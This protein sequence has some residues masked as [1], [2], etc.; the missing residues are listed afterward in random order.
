MMMTIDSRP[1]HGDRKRFGRGGL[2]KRALL[3]A[4]AWSMAALSIDSACGQFILDPIPGLPGLSAGSLAWGDYDHDGRLDF[5]LT[6]SLQLSLW[7]STGLGFSDVTAAAAP[8]IPGLYDSAVAW[9]DFDN[10]GR[11][12]LLITGLTNLSGGAVS[13]LWRNTGSGFTN[14][15]I[16]GL[17]G[18]GE[19][20]VAWSD[21]DGDGRL[22]F[23]IAGTSNGVTSGAVSQLWRNTGNGFTNV[24]I[25]GLTGTYFGAVAWGDYDND[26]RPDFLITG[27]TNSATG[28]TITQLWHNTPSGFTNVP[29]PGL[30]GLY[31]S[32]IAWADYDNDGLL[33]F[34][35]EGLSGN[36]F[37]SELWRNTGSGFTNVPIPGLPGI[38]DGSLAWGDF[39]NDGRPD[40]L[41]TGLTNGTGK[42]SQ[43]WQNTGNGFSNLPIPALEGNFDNSLGCGDFDNDG[44]LDFL[45]S[46]IISGDVVAQLWQNTALSS[47][48]AP[49]APTGLSAIVFGKS[50]ALSWNASVDDRT[51]SLGLS[52]N[53]RIGTTP[54][55][56][57][58]VCPPAL[59]DGRLLLPQLGGA[60]NGSA[61][62][63]DLKPGLTYYWSVQAVDSGFAGS[64]FA[65][66][67]QFR[68]G[69]LI[70]DS[71]SYAAEGF[72]I[73]FSGA[74]GAS[75][76]VLATTDLSS[77]T[78]NAIALGTANE[79]AS[80]QFRFIDPQP[81][82]NQMRFYRVRSP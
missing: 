42:V 74:P 20:A 31:A 19:S 16:S 25:P 21:F 70:I 79:I 58:V 38:A 51:P 82:A 66:E 12:D 49:A 1:A 56:A 78:T 43:L 81:S 57:D 13:Q 59:A 54:G 5:L 77:G 11:L 55:A 52:Y 44:R 64:P 39:D 23:L 8:G 15:P 63:R 10:D 7:H 76:T 3:A 40:F 37:I 26:G 36:T 9:G 30:R 46:G 2:L 18:L 73:R 29:L 80:G 53:V 72:E 60:R 33:D 34:L 69:S 28:A 22:D 32:S 35:M 45:L 71:F 24:P 17:A 50:V 61:T 62:F 67:Q 48:A 47:N 41:I 65:A 14:V 68:A 4:I 6:G 75:F 27:F